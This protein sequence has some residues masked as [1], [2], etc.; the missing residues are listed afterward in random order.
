MAVGRRT[1]VLG[2]LVGGQMQANVRRMEDGRRTDK[3]QTVDN[4]GRIKTEVLVA[5]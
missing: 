1:E 2:V 5:G 3:S 4:A